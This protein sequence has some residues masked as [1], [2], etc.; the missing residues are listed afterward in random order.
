MKVDI[1]LET[2]FEDYPKHQVRVFREGDCY[3][4]QVNTGPK[5]GIVQIGRNTEE[6]LNFLH[7]AL[8]RYS[9]RII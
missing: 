2:V 3:V 4:A 8:E 7:Q 5:E 9:N 1:I 6:A